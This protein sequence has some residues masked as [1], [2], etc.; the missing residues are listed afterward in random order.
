MSLSFLDKFKEKF[1]GF[2]GISSL[3]EK[4]SEIAQVNTLTDASQQ[5]EIETL[6]AEVVALK[7]GLAET[8][9][10]L[11]LFVDTT[12]EGETPQPRDADGNLIPTPTPND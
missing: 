3:D 4:I 11:L 10:A 6:K 9:A 8:Q 5:S 1:K 2:A 12:Y 7:T